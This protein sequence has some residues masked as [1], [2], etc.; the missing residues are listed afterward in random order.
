MQSPPFPRIVIL[1]LSPVPICGFVVFQI[2]GMGRSFC[3]LQSAPFLSVLYAK[4]QPFLFWSGFKFSK[5]LVHLSAIFGTHGNIC[6][7]RMKD[8]LKS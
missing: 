2:I 5:L 8:C 7:V 1:E 3:L 4:G 6:V